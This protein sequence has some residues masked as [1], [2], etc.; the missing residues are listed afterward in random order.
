MFLLTERIPNDI[1][2][3]KA[4]SLENLAV[5]GSSDVDDGTEGPFG[6]DQDGNGAKLVNGISHFGSGKASAGK[7][8]CNSETFEA[9]V[10]QQL[11]GSDSTSL[12]DGQ[13]LLH[14]GRQGANVE[15]DNLNGSA[16][17][18]VGDTLKVLL[19]LYASLIHIC[20]VD[21]TYC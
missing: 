2:C 3:F 1:V 19:V 15:M 7:L 4:H 20:I 12:D 9:V 11:A 13:D 17:D 18:G 14:Y 5:V 6:D 16:R 8:F 10:M 21:I